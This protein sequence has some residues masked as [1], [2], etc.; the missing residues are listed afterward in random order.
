MHLP[1]SAHLIILL[2][3]LMGVELKQFSF[4]YFQTLYYDCSHIEHVPPFLCKFDK[5]FLIFWAVELR[6]Y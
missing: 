1:F 3:F 6:H 5:H 4:L 2:S